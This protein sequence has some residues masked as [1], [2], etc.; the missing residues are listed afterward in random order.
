MKLIADSGSTKT[1][2]RLQDADA[3]IHQF[4]TSGINPYQ[5]SQ[6]AIAALVSKELLPQLPENTSVTELFFYGAGCKAEEKK[7]QLR[8]VFSALFPSAKLSI[9]TD[10]LGA[11]RALFAGGTGIA[12]ILGTGANSCVISDGELVANKRSLG[13]ILGDEGSGA[14]LGKKLVTA[15]LNETISA[16]ISERFYRRFELTPDL[17]LE[18]VYSQPMPNQFLAGFSKFIF[19]NLKEAELQQLAVNAFT[20]FFEMQICSYNN[21]TQYSLGLCGSVAFYYSDII[22]SIAEDKGIRI[23]RILESPIAG[24]SLYHFGE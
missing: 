23:E 4:V 9:E 7:A 15:V 1:A 24:L 11:A 2:W 16:S 17:I 21:Y 12:A 5:L 14:Y 8:T 3:R 22:R 13:F 19:Q 20:E 18:K 6:D 10:L